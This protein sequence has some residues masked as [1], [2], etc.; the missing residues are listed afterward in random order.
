MAY[1]QTDKR[2]A[3][4]KNLSPLS[5]SRYEST[6]YA[7]SKFLVDTDFPFSAR[8]VDGQVNEAKRRLAKKCP[9]SSCLILPLASVRS[10]CRFSILPGRHQ[11]RRC[12]TSPAFH[13]LRRALKFMPP[14][15]PKKSRGQREIV[16]DGGAGVGR[17]CGIEAW[18]RDEHFPCRA[19]RLGFIGKSRNA[20]TSAAFL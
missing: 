1:E 7:R 10:F 14:P 13:F 3:R 15:C 12:Q 16:V 11:S 8:L 6:T 9:Q 18:R 2:A 17:V 20:S 4:N 5:Q 19:I